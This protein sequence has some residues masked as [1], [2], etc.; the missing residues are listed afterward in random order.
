MEK[1][2]CC[3]I[4]EYRQYT[5]HPGKRDVLIGLFDRE[6]VESQEALGMK[7]IGQFRD[8]DHPNL[9]VWLRGFADMRSRT[10]ALEA[11][12]SG[13]A[14]MAHREAANVTMVDYSNVLLLRPADP[15]SGFS[16]AGARRQLP[17]RT[18]PARGLVVTTTCHFRGEVNPDFVEFFRVLLAPVLTDCGASVLASFVSETSANSFPAL[19]VREGEHVFVWFSLFRDLADYDRHVAGF[20]RSALYRDG[21]WDSWKSRFRNPPE[22]QKL[23]PTPRSLLRS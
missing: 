12:Y 1:Q 15:E 10:E 21:V 18:I 2:S 8:A 17:G 7:V 3:P 11:F 23:L 6:L 19:P 20:V 13:A 22:I 4:V 14:W 9:F 16:L 5:L